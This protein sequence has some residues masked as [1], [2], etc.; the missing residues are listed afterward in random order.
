MSDEELQD[1]EAPEPKPESE[2]TWK[3]GG[4]KTQAQRLAEAMVKADLTPSLPEISEL[5]IQKFG[6]PKKFVD[7][8]FKIFNSC[9]GRTKATWMRTFVKIISDAS[10]MVGSADAI[11]E[12]TEDEIEEELR[13]KFRIVKKLNKPQTADA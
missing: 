6:G 2:R 1:F 3:P 7:E 13:T 4:Y 8:A 12:M 5:L 11:A 9:D 10:E